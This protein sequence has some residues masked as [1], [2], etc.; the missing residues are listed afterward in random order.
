MCRRP[1]GHEVSG[2]QARRASAGQSRG[3]YQHQ[4]Q[5]DARRGQPCKRDRAKSTW[6]CTGQPCKEKTAGNGNTRHSLNHERRRPTQHTE[7]LQQL[8]TYRDKEIRSQRQNRKTTS[9]SQR[10]EAR[11]DHN[12]DDPEK[13]SLVDKRRQ[14]PRIQEQCELKDK[15]WDKVAFDETGRTQEGHTHGHRRETA[16]HAMEQCSFTIDGASTKNCNTAD[17]DS[18]E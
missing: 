9:N 4:Q 5:Y 17:Q 18:R 12:H 2:R 11:H 1:S 7:D 15:H 3:N 14:D 6:R 8:R 13:H 10:R 16:K